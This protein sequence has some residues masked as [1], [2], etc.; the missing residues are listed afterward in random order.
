MLICFLI[1]FNIDTFLWQLLINLT[2]YSYVCIENRINLITTHYFK[3][4][5]NTQESRTLLDSLP[6]PFVVL[7]AASMRCW[8]LSTLIKMKQREWMPCFSVS[9]V[10]QTMTFAQKSITHIINQSKGSSRSKNNVTSCVTSFLSNVTVH[11]TQLSQAYLYIHKGS[12]PN[13]LR[14]DKFKLIGTLLLI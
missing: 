11:G 14:G 10:T 2:E 1:S 5:S 9:F 13:N 4:V 12:I 8:V 6:H 3:V 7:I